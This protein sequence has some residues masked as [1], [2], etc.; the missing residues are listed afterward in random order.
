[1]M[2]HKTETNFHSGNK[3]RDAEWSHKPRESYGEFD[4]HF[5][6]QFQFISGCG[7]KGWR[8]ALEARL[9]RFES[10]HPDHLKHTQ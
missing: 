5:R 7:V 3:P 1:M 10:C 6:Y 8:L 2:W 9:C 4:S